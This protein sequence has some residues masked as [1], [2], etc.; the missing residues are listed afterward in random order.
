[1]TGENKDPQNED[2][3]EDE[4]AV[5][6]A[7]ADGDIVVDTGDDNVGD[8]SVE[9]N[10]EELVAQIE[11]ADSEEATAKAEVRNKLE[12]I[13]EQQLDD[14]DSTYNIKLDDDNT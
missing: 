12:D 4:G 14:L 8:L 11:S 6:E 10:V 3:D 2:E 1:M 9:L 7:V 13:R 5:A